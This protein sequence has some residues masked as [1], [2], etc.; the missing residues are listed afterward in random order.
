MAVMSR[1][2]DAWEIRELGIQLPDYIPDKSYLVYFEEYKDKFDL[3][4]FNP[5]VNK[6]KNEKIKEYVL[7]FEWYTLGV[8]MGAVCS[9][10]E[11]SAFIL[12]EYLWE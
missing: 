4:I 2:I 1:L 7:E 12:A 10:D 11:H 6:D 8:Q 5:K 9:L 3:G